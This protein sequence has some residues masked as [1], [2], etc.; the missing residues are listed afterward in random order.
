MT[1]LLFRR[2]KEADNSQCAHYTPPKKATELPCG[3]WLDTTQHTEL[4]VVVLR[5]SQQVQF[6]GLSHILGK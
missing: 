5:A 2:V 6:S 3:L 1:E 4:A